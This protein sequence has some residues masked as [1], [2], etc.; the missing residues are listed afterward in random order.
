MKSK[1]SHFVIG[2]IA[3]FIYTLSMLLG[4]VVNVLIAHA[5]GY[6]E[7][8][9][10]KQYAAENISIILVI[11]IV[12]T[13]NHILFSLLTV[14]L[15]GNYALKKGCLTSKCFILCAIIVLVFAA[16][17]YPV[18]FS[19]NSGWF[20]YLVHIA[21]ILLFGRAFISSRLV[22]NNINSDVIDDISVKSN[23]QES[24][25]IEPSNDNSKVNRAENVCYCHMCGAKI[26]ANSNFCNKCGAKIRIE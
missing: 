5:A 7:Y 4:S 21:G 12:A 25:N 15:V 19:S 26:S 13:I 10:F 17:V 22:S 8:S 9:Q 11:L 16:I 3:W 23:G 20:T 2:L 14:H 1:S 18:I 6:E 24:I